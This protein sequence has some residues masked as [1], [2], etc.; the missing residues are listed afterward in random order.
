VAGTV[1]KILAEN[2]SMV[3]HGQ[4]LVYIQPEA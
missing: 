4:V 3:E 1:V 2:G